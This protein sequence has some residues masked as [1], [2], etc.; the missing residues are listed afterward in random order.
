MKI[1]RGSLP[2]YSE[3]TDTITTKRSDTF[4]YIKNIDT[5]WKKYI[6]EYNPGT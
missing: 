1:K 2:N 3:V 6:N 5:N 4:K